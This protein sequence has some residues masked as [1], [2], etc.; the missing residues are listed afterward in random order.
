MTALYAV[1]MHLSIIDKDLFTLKNGKY[2]YL[3]INL[4]YL[5]SIKMYFYNTFM[6]PHNRI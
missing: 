5:K 1:A 3:N 4:L 2:K 6:F